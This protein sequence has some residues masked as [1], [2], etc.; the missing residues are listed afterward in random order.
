MLIIV[1]ARPL[2]QMV[3]SAMDDCCHPHHDHSF[4]NCHDHDYFAIIMIILI[5]RTIIM[6]IM[7][8]SRPLKQMVGSA[9]D[10]C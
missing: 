8:V 4:P 2:K 10:D 9:M 5:I 3:G 1:A 6:I 7:I